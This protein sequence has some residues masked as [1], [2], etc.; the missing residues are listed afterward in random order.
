MRKNPSHAVANSAVSP[1]AAAFRLISTETIESLNVTLQTWYH[2]ASRCVHYHLASESDENVCLIGLRTVPTD[3]TGVAHILEHTTLCGS[4]RYPVRDPFFMMTRRSLNT[5]MNAFTSAD[6]TAYPFASENRKDFFNLLDVYLDAVFFPTLNE[7]DFA[8]EGH[9]IE[10]ADPSDADS[11][12][13]YKGVVYNEMK[14]AMSSSMSQLW[15]AVTRHLFPSSTYHH[16]S[17]GDP[18]EITELSYEQLKQFYTTHYHPSN[19]V[20]MTFG[21][22]PVED[23]QQSLH[24]KALAH[25]NAVPDSVTPSAA[26]ADEGLSRLIAIPAEK[27]YAAPVTAIEHYPCEADE[28]T[29]LKNKTH[30]VMGWLLGDGS[31]LEQ[32]LEAH[33]LANVLLE[34]S[35]SPLM[36]AIETTDLGNSPSGLC[37][38]EDSFREMVFVCGLEGSERSHIEAF[39]QLVLGVLQDIA[40]HGIDQEKL[41][42]VLHQ[43]ELS[44]REISGDGYPYG[45]QL[46]LAGL[47]PA[48]AGINPGSHLDI[49]EAL[50][51]LRQKITDPD[52]I[53]QLV[54]RL[55]LDNSH[56]VTVALV[57]DEQMAA[58][59][60][61]MEAG[62]LADIKSRLSAGQKQQLIDR[63]E[64]L[65]ARQ[66][67][68]DKPD[69]LPK[70]GLADVPPNKPMVKP[71][72]AYG[73]SNDK[74]QVL[75][76]Y[77]Q[78]T[79]GLVY[80][81]YVS[82]IPSLSDEELR[83][84]PLLS[85]IIPE[86]GVGDAGYLQI[87]E[88]QSASTGGIGAFTQYRG[89]LDTSAFCGGAFILGGKALERNGDKLAD[90][91]TRTMAD[92]RFDELDRIHE[93]CSQILTRR[94]ERVTGSGHSL[95]MSLAASG[96]S[97]SA[98]VG[99]TMGGI[100]SIPWLRETIAGFT[101]RAKLEAFAGK[102]ADLHRKLLGEPGQLAAIGESSFLRHGQS[103]VD[104]FGAD[105]TLG[106]TD[107]NLRTVRLDQPVHVQQAWQINSQVNFASI[108]VPTVPADHPDNAALTVIG[109][110]MRNGYLHRAVREQGGAYGGGAAQDAS[111]CAFKFYSYRDPRL[112]DT[113]KDFARS[114][115]WL[116]ETKIEEAALEEA[117][118]GVIGG[119]DKPRSPAGEGKTAFI[120]ALFGRDDAYHARFRSSVLNTGA[121]ELKQVAERYLTA[122]A[123]AARHSVGL[124]VG[125]R[126]AAELDKSRFSLRKL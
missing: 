62:K 31:D 18:A 56:R 48:L 113:L 104:R 17:G 122:A 119:L 107:L 16:N 47:S 78:G 111:S 95:A 6:W 96:L 61:A 43:L 66:A 89:P 112:N 115:D 114:V 77:D 72:D 55:L 36:Q 44:Q 94:L 59:Q 12:L 101:D 35:A 86:L 30:I 40:E 3:S 46:I 57:P 28:D 5:F 49:D 64:A 60:A 109:N 65:T 37:G 34:H 27:R 67:S 103:I 54:R 118:L 117:I 93:L 29:G 45:L 85:A 53:C 58:R 63:A 92:C 87:Q 42:S 11:P 24:D 108:A 38:L 98:A 39:E 82:S 91:M 8:Q 125:E 73:K 33:L 52:Y 106:M 51:S 99:Y 83:L 22:L 120:N 124:V 123:D 7:L 126:G 110:L 100:E 81:Q 75:T 10:V 13:V 4:Q 41:Q 121:T 80:L 32:N 26:A 70:V 76:A 102:L 25:F 14:G 88:E 21:N 97:A 20:I 84:L 71:A 9:R 69:I 2:E 19:A 116:L 23:I 50:E 15:A 105:L 79:N 1:A 74:G 68:V 90:L